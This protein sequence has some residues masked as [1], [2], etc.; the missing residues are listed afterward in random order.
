MVVSKGSGLYQH[1]EEEL[2]GADDLVRLVLIGT[3][4]VAVFLLIQPSRSARLAGALW[5]LLP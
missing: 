5:F 3:I 1:A 2:K 4:V